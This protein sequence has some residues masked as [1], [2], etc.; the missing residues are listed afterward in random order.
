MTAGPK[1]RSSCNVIC[2]VLIQRRDSS[3]S[4][5]QNESTQR[6]PHVK[7]K[8]VT[9]V[10]IILGFQGVRNEYGGFESGWK[11]HGM[12]RTRA[13]WNNVNY[14]REGEELEKKRERQRD[15]ERALASKLSS[16]SKVTLTFFCGQLKWLWT[17]ERTRNSPFQTHIIIWGKTPENENERH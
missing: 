17:N 7:W 13:E 6:K 12:L 1:T 8:G 11:R 2:V 15:I 4:S 10:G 9:L 16:V 5:S 3:E 14:M